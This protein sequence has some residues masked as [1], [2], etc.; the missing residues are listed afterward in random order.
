[1][2]EPIKAESDILA[3]PLHVRAEMATKAASIKL[4]KE[5]L[6]DGSP[7]YIW[8]DGQVVAVPPQEFQY[9]LSDTPTE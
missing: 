6:V 8:R 5:R 9:L 7:L 2:A 3:L 1:M 4:V